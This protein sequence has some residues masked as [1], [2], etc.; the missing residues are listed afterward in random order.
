MLYVDE[1]SIRLPWSQDDT[2]EAVKFGEF[3][4]SQI[5]RLVIVSTKKHFVNAWSA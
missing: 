2:F 5:R 3:A 4:Y 1:T